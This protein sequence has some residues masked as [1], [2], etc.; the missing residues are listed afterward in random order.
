M[1]VYIYMRK[2]IN[3]KNFTSIDVTNHQ[4]QAKK[5]KFDVSNRQ[6]AKRELIKANMIILPQPQN[7]IPDSALLR[8][9][10]HHT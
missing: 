10:F 5:K 8:N 9:T 4:L 3:T 7:K 2:F 6:E 1:C